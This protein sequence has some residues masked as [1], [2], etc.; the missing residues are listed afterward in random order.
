MSRSLGA[1]LPADLL[2]LLSQR[3]LAPLLGRGIPLVTLGADGRP[4]PMLCSYLELLAMSAT[5]LRLAIAVRSRSAA[6]LQ[7]QGVGTFL[8][9]EPERSVYLKCRAVGPPRVVFGN[10]ARFEL[11]VE[12]VLEDA[13]TEAEGPARITSGITYAP[14]PDL[15]APWVKALLA[16]L[17]AT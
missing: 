4:H 15:D 7:S 17:R 8:L 16:A 1:A 14:A 3:D 13:P 12:D 11:T 6:N 9:V 5:A 2:A 10:L